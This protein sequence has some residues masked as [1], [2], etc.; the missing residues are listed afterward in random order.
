[1]TAVPVPALSG[2]KHKNGTA[3]IAVQSAGGGSPTGVNVLVQWFKND[4]TTPSK[5]TSGVTSNGIA[6]VTSGTLKGASS[7]AVC[8]ID[9]SGSGFDD[10]GQSYPVCS[11]NYGGGGGGGG[12]GGT[13]AIQTA[14]LT[15]KG[16]GPVKA[17][18]SWTGGDA[19]VD[20][21]YNGNLLT[22]SVS[23]TGSYTHNLGKNPT[24]PHSYQVCNPGA[25][26]AECS[27]EVEAT[28]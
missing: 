22:G 28:P 10:V 7:I 26:P 19:T 17:D 14:Q 9:L 23:N 18:L 4:A 25:D 27:D 8:V 3:D 15:Q 1:V 11:S 5:T 21:Y 2:R 13:P 6:T 16:N 24:G 12:G 20:V